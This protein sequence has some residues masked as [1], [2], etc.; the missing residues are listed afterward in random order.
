MMQDGFIR[1]NGTLEQ[2]DKKN[3]HTISDIQGILKI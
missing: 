2:A 3:L 1:L